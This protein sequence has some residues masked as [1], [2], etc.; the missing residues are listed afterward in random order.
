MMF[1]RKVRLRSAAVL[2]LLPLLTVGAC[3]T[4]SRQQPLRRPV[5]ALEKGRIIRLTDRT[6]ETG[7]S[8]TV[9]FGHLRSGEIAVVQL[10]LANQTTQPIILSDYRSSCGCTT[11]DFDTQ[12]IRPGE[13]QRLALTF[14][15]R[16]EWGWQLKSVDLFV[17][18]S[19]R[20][21]R[22]FVE[23]DVE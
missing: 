4:R 9:R 19:N 17:A 16:G 18:G 21:F 1:S 15:S 13:A 23:A 5:D 3:T 7:G 6:L 10:W 8:D 11:L 22:L 2:L 12:P 14:D 20:P